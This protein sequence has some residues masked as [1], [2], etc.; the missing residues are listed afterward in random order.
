MRKM[1]AGMAA[2]LM[3]AACNQNQKTDDGIE[4]KIIRTNDTARVVAKGD[5]LMVDVKA[6]VGENDTVMFDTY[7]NKRPFTLPSDEPTLKSV[8][9]LLKKGDSAMFF[10]IADT[11]YQKSMQQ[12][13]PAGI[14]AGDKIKFTI[15]I[16]DIYSQQELQDRQQEK[17]MEGIM[18][19]S[20]AVL[21]YSEG[22]NGLVTTPSGLKYMVIKAGKGKSVKKDD[23][24]M[25]K[26]KGTL[27]NGTLFDETKPGQPDFTF[28]VGKQ[29]VIPGWDEGLQLMKEGDVFKFI[30]PW[31]LAYGPS[32]SGPIPPFSSLVFEVE[33]I[34]VN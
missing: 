11:F 5:M 23:K 22:L 30:I 32:G 25:V 29:Q 24:V 13:L 26:Y 8:F 2:L 19:D 27:L 20:L 17:A 34:K 4:Y 15:S 1:L 33:L 12:P 10:I 7:S 21:K 6:V 28:N 14:H 16:L 31:Q 18:M 3:L 9:A